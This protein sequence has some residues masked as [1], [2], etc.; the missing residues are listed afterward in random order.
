[1]PLQ[2]H[3]STFD[4]TLWTLCHYILI[5]LGHDIND[6]NWLMLCKENLSSVDRLNWRIDEK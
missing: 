2:M 4:Q 3:N 1:M 6:A 5:P